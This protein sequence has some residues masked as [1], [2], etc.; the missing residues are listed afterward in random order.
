MI[1]ID[2][3][4][5]KYKDPNLAVPSILQRLHVPQEKIHLDVG[6]YVIFGNDVSACTELKNADDYLNSIKNG[7][8]NDELLSISSSNYDYGILLVY[9]SPSQALI[10]TEMRRSVWFNFLA[11]C[12][13]DVSPVG[14]GSKISVISVETPYDAAFFLATLHKKIVSGNIYREP[15]A[16]KIK[17][18]SGK[19]Q[20]YTTQWMFPPSCHIGRKRASLLL[21]HFGTI[22]NI[23]TASRDEI[24]S[25]DGIGSI[26]ADGMI[27][28]L[29]TESRSDS[30]DITEGDSGQHNRNYI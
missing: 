12:V 25:I 30:N 9:G 7:R 11:G 27:N 17:I 26:I 5:R 4:E 22:K 18:P 13:T 14:N 2:H 8:L 10:N 20:V 21:Q 15:T 16:Q 3:R 29:N 6:D 24:L 23:V 1:Q 19:E 28:H